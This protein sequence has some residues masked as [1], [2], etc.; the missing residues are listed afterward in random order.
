M[1]LKAVLAVG[2]LA[3]ASINA[4]AVVGPLVFDAG[5]NTFFNNTPGASFSDQYT[6]TVSGS[7]GVLVGSI[8]SSV[9][10]GKDVDFSFINISSGAGAP[11]YSFTQDAGDPDEHWSLAGV[12]LSAG[13]NY[14]LTV[15]GTQAGTGLGG[16][17]GEMSISPVPEPETYLLMLA[18]L[19]AIGFVARRRRP[20]RSA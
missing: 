13:V 8:T 15:S 5:G 10:S 18:G 7:S 4:M 6:F 9:N 14:V 17:S 2:I 16:Y 11:T 19:S 20:L 3:G 12:A 1:K